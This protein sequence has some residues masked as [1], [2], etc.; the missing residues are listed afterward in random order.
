MD[1][2]A[3]K[4]V[5]PSIYSKLAERENQGGSRVKRK[6]PMSWDEQMD[7]DGKS[8]KLWA[9]LQRRNAKEETIEDGFGSVWSKICERCK[10][11]SMEVV[12]PGK[13]QCAFCG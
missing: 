11:P 6:K 12:R 13:A 2:Q 10:R 3:Q 8:G 9:A 5:G 7:A 1:C 4:E